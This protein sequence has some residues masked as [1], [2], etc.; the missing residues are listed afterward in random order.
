MAINFEEALMSRCMC[1]WC[2]KFLHWVN[3]EGDSHGI[4]EECIERELERLEK[5]VA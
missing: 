2:G 1:A 4:C 3:C 5:E